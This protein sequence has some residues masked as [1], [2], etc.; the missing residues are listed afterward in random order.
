MTFNND[1][2]ICLST[3]III[4][5]FTNK[6]YIMSKITK[7]LTRIAKSQG[8]TDTQIQELLKQVPITSTIKAK[9]SIDPNAVTKV[10]VGEYK[11]KP[12]I[13]LLKG[14]SSF[15]NQPFTFGK[16]KAKLIVEQFE[17]IKQFALSE[18]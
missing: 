10:S 11:G 5:W 15:V 17:A 18:V 13:S 12:T 1:G 4:T 14:D 2:V 6:D 9:A 8:M 7:E 3:R 16:A